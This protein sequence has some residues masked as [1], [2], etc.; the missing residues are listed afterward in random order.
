MLDLFRTDIDYLDSKLREG[1][2][3]DKYAYIEDWWKQ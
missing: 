1:L 2:G 3:I